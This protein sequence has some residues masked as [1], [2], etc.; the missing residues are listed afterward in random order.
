MFKQSGESF[1]GE[2]TIWLTEQ[3]FICSFAD[4][5]STAA[6]PFTVSDDCRRGPGHAHSRPDNRRDVSFRKFWDL[7]GDAKCG[8]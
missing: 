3:N 4:T 8:E 1:V 5:V 7:R 6:T 2:L